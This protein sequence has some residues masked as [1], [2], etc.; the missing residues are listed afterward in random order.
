[1]D[2]DRLDFYPNCN[3]IPKYCDIKSI[4]VN[5]I[6]SMNKVILDSAHSFHWS[7]ILNPKVLAIAS[8]FDKFEE[9][10]FWI[11]MFCISAII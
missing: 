9:T 7:Y 10:H 11:E 3:C 6:K 1:M 2:I 5:D 4:R 8:K